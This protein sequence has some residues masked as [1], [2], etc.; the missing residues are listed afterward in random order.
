MRIRLYWVLFDEELHPLIER[1]RHRGRLLAEQHLNRIIGREAH[2]VLGAGWMR[3]ALAI[4]T[5]R[6]AIYMVIIGHSFL[7]FA[8]F[9]IYWTLLTAIVVNVVLAVHF[10]SY[11]TV[12]ASPAFNTIAAIFAILQSALTVTWA[13]VLA[14][15]CGR[16]RERQRESVYSWVRTITVWEQFV[17]KWKYSERR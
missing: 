4:W 14:T 5:V 11:G 7:R 17:S 15:S 8:R 13:A 9:G 12:A 16:E 2:D 3:A 1:G 6:H 10:Q